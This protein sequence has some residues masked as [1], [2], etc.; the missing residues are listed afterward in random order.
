MMQKY[1]KRREIQ[2]SICEICIKYADFER[3]LIG[4]E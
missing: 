4:A 2:I 1:T 3:I